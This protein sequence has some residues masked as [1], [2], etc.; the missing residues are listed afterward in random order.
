MSEKENRLSFSSSIYDSQA[1]LSIQP[2]IYFGNN[3]SEY[4]ATT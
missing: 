1:Q 2:I 4:K 3:K